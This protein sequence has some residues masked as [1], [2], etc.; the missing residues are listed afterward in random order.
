MGQVWPSLHKSACTKI[1]ILSRNSQQYFKNPA[2]LKILLFRYEFWNKYLQTDIPCCFERYQFLMVVKCDGL[3]VLALSPRSTRHL[4]TTPVVQFKSG[5]RKFQNQTTSPLPPSWGSVELSRLLVP[6]WTCLT[7][8][9]FAATFC[10]TSA[11]ISGT[12]IRIQC[13]TTCQA[14]TRRPVDFW[15]PAGLVSPTLLPS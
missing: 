13:H 10:L 2:V 1:F 6:S 12:L 14:S 5:G 11:L 4:L 8:W 9:W 7:F 3:D 15:C